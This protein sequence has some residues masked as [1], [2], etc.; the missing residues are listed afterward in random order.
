MALVVLLF[1]DIILQLVNPQILRSFIDAAT[2]HVVDSHIVFSAV[3]FFGIALLT[4]V[5]TVAT[6]YVGTNIGWTATNAMRADLAQHC[7]NLDMSFHNARTPGEMIDRLDGDITLLS[8][9]FSQLIIQIFGNTLL[10]IGVL[11][12]LFTVDWRVG[13]AFLLFVIMAVLVLRKLRTFAV[14]LWVK[15]RQASAESYGFIEERLAGTEDIRSNGARSYVIR[16]FVEIMRKRL[17]TQRRAGLAASV[18]V[19][20]TLFL[21]VIG[22]VVA[23]AVSTYLFYAHLITIG[24]VYLIYYY[25]TMLTRPIEVITQQMD[26]LQK[27]GASISRMQEL[28]ATRNEIIDGSEPFQVAGALSVQFEDVT[29]G[30]QPDEPVLRDLSFELQPGEVLGLLGRTGSGKTSTTRLLLRLYDPQQGTIRLNG[31]DIRTLRLSDLRK[32]IGMVTQDV[33]LFHATVRDNLT[34]FD[35][36]IADGRILEILNELGLRSWLDTLPAGLDT[37]LEAG[38]GGL[39]AGQAQLL[40][41]TRIFLAD[42]GLV[43]LDEASSRLDPATEQLLERAVSRLLHNRTAII[44]A[45]RLVTVNRADKILLLEHGQIREFGVRRQLLLNPESR[46]A[47]LLRTELQEVLV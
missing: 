19:N 33:Q 21:V 25:S 39:S 31:Q 26:D 32:R 34:L 40:A 43:I 44:I 4:Q 38:G 2:T 47:R 14:P 3:L 37:E 35:R 1:S 5:V 7:L 42:P 8:N 41:L 6:T 28:Y 24:T 15:A 11:A 45:H 16:R 12:L 36:S 23:F 29:F 17:R 13:L 27:V 30:Y 20:A 46:Y 22:T 10:L 9:F 18:M